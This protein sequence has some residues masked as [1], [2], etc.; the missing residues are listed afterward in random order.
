MWSAMTDRQESE[1]G[2][3]D[4]DFSTRGNGLTLLCG[5]EEPI[6]PY[7]GLCLFVQSKA[8]A[9]LNADIL[10]QSIC[11]HH[12]R[13]DGH[14]NPGMRYIRIYKIRVNRV[15]GEGRSVR[16]RV[17]MLV[18]EFRCIRHGQVSLGDE[19]FGRSHRS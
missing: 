4:H 17:V 19:D 6:L 3:I 7:G 14:L 8:E 16:Q 18:F 9:A 5:G 11:S 10:R 13:N 2:E 15:D 1:F 12:H